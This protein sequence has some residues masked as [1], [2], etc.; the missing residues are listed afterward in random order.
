MGGGWSCSWWVCSAG[1][2]EHLIRFDHPLDPHTVIP[3]F[4]PPQSF[5]YLEKALPAS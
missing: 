1:M 3:G 2:S 4:V 5:R